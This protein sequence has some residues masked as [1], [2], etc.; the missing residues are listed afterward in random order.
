MINPQPVNTP[1]SPYRNSG[2]APRPTMMSGPSLSPNGNQAPK[3]PRKRFPWKRAFGLSFLAL[4]VGA[5]T[6][7]YAQ[8]RNLTSNIIQDHEGVSSE[9]L[10]YNPSSKTAL[11]TS[12]FVKNGDGRFNMVIVGIGGENHPGG[13]LTDSIQV[14]SIDTINNK[15][16]FTSVP[17]DLYVNY[18][19][20]G[21][22]KINTVYTYAEQKKP[23]SG[24]LAVRDMVGQV[25]GINI[26]N[27]ALIDFTGIKQIVDALGGIEVDVPKALNDPLY[28]A[29]DMIHYDPL[30]VKA[31]PQ[32]MNGELALKYSRSRETTSDFDR[33]MRQQLVIAA[34]KKKALTLGVLTNPTKVNN[35]ITALGKHFK[36]DLQVDNIRQ[37]ISLY[38]LV[39]PENT[40]GF[41]LDTSSSLGLLTAVSSPVYYAYP[42]AGLDKYDDINQWFAKNSPDPL[43][44]RESPSV[45]VYNS[46]KA[47]TKQ[48]TAFVQK[49]KDYGYTV[50][51]SA[52]TPSGK[53]TATR[54][55]AKDPNAKPIS[56]NYLGTLLKAT[57]EKGTVEGTSTSD[58]EVIY[59]PTATAASIPSSKP[60][61][62]PTATPSATP[63]S[64]AT[65]PPTELP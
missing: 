4:V 26:S 60:T 28:P 36:T 18:N 43:L 55:L 45:T 29:A 65:E 38:Q 13:N 58:Y 20:T 39:T 34:I 52:D 21:R 59:V 46:G 35:L 61:S 62:K 15:L 40:T 33:S 19:G 57:V 12:K 5:S 11:D 64:T 54:I 17:R 10:N 8:Y 44:A 30:Y 16:S 14:L 51:L 53:T 50:T 25:L 27:F 47:S 32:T 7:T 24:A 42:I 63:D 23:G 9:I 2:S 22:A 41:T 31:G 37:L 56:H 3:K 1:Q 49:L 48:M 6:Y